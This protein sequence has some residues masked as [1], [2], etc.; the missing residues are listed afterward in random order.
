MDEKVYHKNKVMMEDFLTQREAS[1]F[2][3]LKENNRNSLYW[4]KKRLAPDV[5]FPK[6]GRNVQWPKTF[7]MEVLNTKSW[8]ESTD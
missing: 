4:W 3:G 1:R 5:V 6:F 8:Q 7:L 2:L